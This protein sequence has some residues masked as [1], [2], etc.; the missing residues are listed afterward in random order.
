MRKARLHE[1]IIAYSGVV[2]FYYYI[3]VPPSAPD[4]FQIELNYC[5]PKGI[6]NS[7]KESF[8]PKKF[9][10][11]TY[12]DLEIKIE[13]IENVNG[14][15]ETIESDCLWATYKS[16][17]VMDNCRTNVISSFS[18]MKSCIS[19][20]RDKCRSLGGVCKK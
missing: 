14:V 6:I 2:I 5:S 12:V 17:Q 15:K 20:A 3:L 13:K 19:Y 4:S 11:G 7:I 16:K 1:K 18:K 9:W 8:N 10:V